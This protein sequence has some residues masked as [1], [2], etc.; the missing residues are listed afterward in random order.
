MARPMVV[1]PDPDSPT[2]PNTSP[3]RI[4]KSTPCTAR[5]GGDPKR[6]G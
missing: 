2:S 6:P 5:N 1:L 4:V 3:E